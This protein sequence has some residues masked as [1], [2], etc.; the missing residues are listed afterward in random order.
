MDE[1]EIVTVEESPAPSASPSEAPSPSPSPAADLA[2]LSERVERIDQTLA[3][4]LFS[5]PLEDYTVSEGLLLGL[6][7]AVLVAGVVTLIRR[8]FTW[9]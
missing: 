6:L 3:H 7:V 1:N 5:T 4:P 2:A 9:L 8:A